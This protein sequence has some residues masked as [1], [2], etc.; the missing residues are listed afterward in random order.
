M[1]GWGGG[2][3]LGRVGDDLLV[4]ETA[5]DSLKKQEFFLSFKNHFICHL[6][7]KMN[8]KRLGKKFM[9]GKSYSILTNLIFETWKHYYMDINFLFFTK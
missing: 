2:G 1:S 5:K 9:T 7:K 6:L 8:K 3:G 4:C